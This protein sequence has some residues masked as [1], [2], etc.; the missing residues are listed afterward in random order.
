MRKKKKIFAAFI[1][2]GMIASSS[3][4]VNIQASQEKY[5][6]NNVSL[7]SKIDKI[8]KE[9]PDIVLPNMGIYENEK[10]IVV[11]GKDY[12]KKDSDKEEQVC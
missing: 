1:T 9:I 6:D 12:M 5:S 8:Q 3:G 11:N 10:K 2:A 7:I 4:V